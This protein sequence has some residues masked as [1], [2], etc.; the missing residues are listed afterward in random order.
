MCLESWCAGC[1]KS[2]ALI[3]CM[4]LCTVCAKKQENNY[5]GVCQFITF[6]LSSA[7]FDIYK[8]IDTAL[9]QRTALSIRL[10][11][12]RVGRRAARP[13]TIAA[14]PGRAMSYNNVNT[15]VSNVGL[16]YIPS[17]VDVNISATAAFADMLT[18]NGMAGLEKLLRNAAV[19]VKSD[20]DATVLQDYTLLGYKT[21][22]PTEHLQQRLAPCTRAVLLL[23]VPPPPAVVAGAPTTDG[24]AGTKNIAVAAGA[25]TSA[26]NVGTESS[27]DT[28]SVTGSGSI[29]KAYAYIMHRRSTTATMLRHKLFAGDM[30]LR[31]PE[32]AAEWMVGF[33]PLAAAVATPTPQVESRYWKRQILFYGDS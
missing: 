9:M 10:S 18:A 1:A 7:N 6:C 16:A 13:S 22:E 23:C 2:M 14:P 20:D 26:A 33:P 15:S 3:R 24:G 11:V 27:V 19:P 29:D 25:T 28:R 5:I 32:C 4:S 8:G 17:V 31:T 30:L 21:L 12:R